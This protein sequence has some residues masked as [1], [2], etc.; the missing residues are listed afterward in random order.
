MI[1][2]PIDD[3]IHYKSRI[4]NCDA[5]IAQFVQ[6]KEKT[7]SKAERENYEKCIEIWEK[8]IKHTKRIIKALAALNSYFIYLRHHVYKK[9]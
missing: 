1:E 6:I 8:E 3:L 7:C 2:H 4:E 5:M 9:N